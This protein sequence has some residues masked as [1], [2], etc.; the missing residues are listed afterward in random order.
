MITL[1]LLQPGKELPIQQ[2]TF[3]VAEKISI[4]RSSENEVVL[5]SAVV[6][7][8]HLTI[9]KNQTGE[10]IVKSLGTNGTYVEGELVVQTTA[11]D[12]MIMRLAG[13]GPQLQINIQKDVHALNRK[14][15]KILNA[16]NKLSTSR[17]TELEFQEQENDEE[18]TGQLLA[19]K[20]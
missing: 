20:L 2:W 4:G 16:K 14:I 9:L 12:G 8:K 15:G 19:V 5:Y 17:D 7:R 6:S 10:W 11:Y 18:S 13:S 1:T 3:D